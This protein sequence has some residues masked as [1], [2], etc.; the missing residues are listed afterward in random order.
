[1]P[2]YEKAT[3]RSC[4]APILWVFTMG[5]GKRMPVDWLPGKGGTLRVADHRRDGTPVVAYVKTPAGGELLYTCHF[6][7]C[8]NARVH[9]R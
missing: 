8:P 4:M 2:T 3:C 9:R 5:A 1:M 6:A 7:T